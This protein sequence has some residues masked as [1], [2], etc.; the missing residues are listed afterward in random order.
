MR[1]PLKLM[2]GLLLASS[3]AHAVPQELNFQ[4]RLAE[5]GVPA[6]GSKQM[7]FRIY[8]APTGGTALF[9]EERTISVSSGIFNALVGEGTSGGIPISV[10]DG[11]DRYVEVQ[12]G[13]TTL[14]R[15]K[16]TSVAHAFRAATAEA[17][18]ANTAGDIVLGRSAI[19]ASGALI[20]P[21]DYVPTAPEH[22][23]TKA[24]VDSQG[25]GIWITSGS[26]VTLADPTRDVEI[27]KTG[28]NI[29]YHARLYKGDSALAN[30]GFIGAAARGTAEAPAAS[31]SGDVLALFGGNGHDGAIFSSGSVR[32]GIFMRAAQS[33][34]PTQQGTK[35]HFRNTPNDSTVAQD[36]MVLTN[37]GRLGVGTT[38]PKGDLEVRRT[39]ATARYVAK[40]FS[41]DAPSHYPSYAGVA[42]RGT[43]NTPAPSQTDDILSVFGGNAHDGTGYHTDGLPA[44]VVMYADQPWS[45]TQHGTRMAFRTTP[46]DST[47]TKQQMVLTND[48]RLGI[49]TPV[50]DAL[51]HL[52]SGA[53][54]AI[55]IRDTTQREHWVLTSD[56]N[57][58]GT[59]RRP[60]GAMENEQYF[61]Y[62]PDQPNIYSIYFVAPAPPRMKVEVWGGGG[63]A[64][65]AS[66]TSNIAHGVSGAGGAGGYGR[67]FVDIQPGTT[68]WILVGGGGSSG[69]NAGNGGPGGVTVFGTRNLFAQPPSQS[70][71][72]GPGNIVYATGGQGGGGGRRGEGGVGGTSNAPF[73]INGDYGTS[74]GMIEFINPDL[75]YYIDM[76]G[77]P[78]GVAYSGAAG[79]GG[80]GTDNPDEPPDRGG[81]GLVILTY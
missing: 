16:M 10:F 2:F 51:L 71:P 54:G 56:A 52:S 59:W 43:E 29:R 41:D 36:Q 66:P 81:D 22:A 68:Y 39:G 6:A 72:T 32:T 19:G 49:G 65:A 62:I 70:D 21:G 9:T 74:G 27:F 44:S 57:G 18:S 38:D 79:G 28:E 11:T 60:A 8:D 40:T 75:A 78:G 1:T 63:G 77:V 15:Q 48:G 12:V 37:D 45:T 23:A 55:K 5:A 73:A 47:T 80:W 33:W 7:I 4:G 42:A 35:I 67:T 26:L 64:G 58:V 50:P 24:Y 61:K 76:P 3:L 34:S 53:P 25:A 46:N 17:L 31:Q 13:T 14:P 20:F 69:V 30:P